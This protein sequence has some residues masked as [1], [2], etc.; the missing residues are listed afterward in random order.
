MQ[1]PRP[2]WEPDTPMSPRDITTLSARYPR[3]TLWIVGGLMVVLSFCLIGG[4]R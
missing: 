1:H 2:P 3:S 4:I